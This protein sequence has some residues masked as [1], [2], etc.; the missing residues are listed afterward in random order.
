MA[1]KPKNKD[2]HESLGVPSADEEV[3]HDQVEEP[4]HSVTER[5]KDFFHHGKKES[6]KSGIEEHSKFD[7]FKKGTV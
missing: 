5:V 4:K 1:K 2:D 3:D 6:P 7:K